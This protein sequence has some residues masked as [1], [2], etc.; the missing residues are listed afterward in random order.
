LLELHYLVKQSTGGVDNSVE[1]TWLG[2]G[3]QTCQA[4]LIVSQYQANSLVAGSGRTQWADA[5]GQM[6]LAN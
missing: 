6:V 2:I 1:V 3:T 5:T 4:Q